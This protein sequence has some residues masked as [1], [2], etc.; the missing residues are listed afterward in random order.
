M[1]ASGNIRFGNNY[2]V[3]IGLD[4]L[5]DKDP[6]CLNANPTATPFPTTCTHNSAGATYDPLGRTYF[7]SM[8]MNF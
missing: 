8:R 5:F 6:P 4:N 2:T 1:S 7:V 3:S